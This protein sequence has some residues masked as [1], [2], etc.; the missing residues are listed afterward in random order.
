MD[1]P[2]SV[3]LPAKR[4]SGSLVTGDNQEERYRRKAMAGLRPSNRSLVLKR[5]FRDLK[6]AGAEKLF[7]ENVSSVAPRQQLETAI[8]FA[9]EGD[10]CH[11]N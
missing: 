6:A 8:E 3:Q 9:R 7:R 4:L 10:T 2:G 5:R 11:E 1:E